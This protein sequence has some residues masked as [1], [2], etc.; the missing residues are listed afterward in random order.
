MASK[1]VKGL[2]GPVA[3]MAFIVSLIALGHTIYNQIDQNRR[4]DALNRGR[5]D[6]TDTG[7]TAFKLMTVDEVKKTDRGFNLTFT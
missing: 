5:I 3:L 6:I 1:F 7:F 2:K 4:W